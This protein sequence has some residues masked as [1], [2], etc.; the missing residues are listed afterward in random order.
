[1]MLNIS[2]CINM[3]VKW[4]HFT[5]F[6]TKLEAI[7]NI[8]REQIYSMSLKL[9]NCNV[10]EYATGLNVRF[11]QGNYNLNYFHFLTKFQYAHK[12]IL[13]KSCIWNIYLFSLEQSYFYWPIVPV[14][15]AGIAIKSFLFQS[16]LSELIS[17]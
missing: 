10:C 5:L 2:W 16:R 9:S 12:R 11:A 15:L 14:L 17:F 13:H 4:S 1:M 7:S 6:S 8:P 3:T